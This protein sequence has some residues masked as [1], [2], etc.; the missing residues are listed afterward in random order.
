MLE[1][2]NAQSTMQKDGSKKL[3]SPKKSG[4]PEAFDF[5]YAEHDGISTTSTSV[6]KQQLEPVRVDPRVTKLVDGISGVLDDIPPARNR[7]FINQ[8]SKQQEG[9]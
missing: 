8:K 4:G 2:E 9:W 5:R 7:I 3:L 6:K 1:F